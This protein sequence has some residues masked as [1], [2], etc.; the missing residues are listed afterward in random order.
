MK[1][2]GVGV[3]LIGHGL[4]LVRILVPN[5]RPR[6]GPEYPFPEVIRIIKRFQK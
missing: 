2:M 4:H 6:P 5:E 3:T 1:S